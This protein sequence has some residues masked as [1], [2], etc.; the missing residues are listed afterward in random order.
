MDSLLKSVSHG[1]SR[2][3]KI[4]FVLLVVEKDTGDTGTQYKHATLTSV[5]TKEKHTQ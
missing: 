3:L 2:P 4:F 5:S 1:I